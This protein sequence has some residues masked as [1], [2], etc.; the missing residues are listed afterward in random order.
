[1]STGKE[2]QQIIVVKRDVLFQEAS[3]QGFSP[4]NVYDYESLI[5]ENATTMR[6]GST[7]EPANHPLGNAEMNPNFKQPIGYAVI[8]NPAEERVFAYQRASNSDYGEQRLRG[9]WSWGFGG[10][11][12]SSDKKNGDENFMRSSKLREI[13]EEVKFVDGEIKSISLGGYINDDSNPVGKVHFGILYFV[14]V[15]AARIVPRDSEIARIE[16]KTFSELEELCR[17][18]EM[19]VETWSR[20]ALEPLRALRK[21]L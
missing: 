7:N 12:E 6:R 10:H 21:L 11:V 13:G 1:M 2:D 19:N 4:T 14:G 18:P 20:I 17:N 15:S 5:L 3:F 8:F 16:A 9:K